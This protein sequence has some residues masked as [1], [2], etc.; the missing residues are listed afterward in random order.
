MTL[1]SQALNTGS[2]QH[3]LLPNMGESTMEG[4]SD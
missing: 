1:N 4:F 3:Q 2:G